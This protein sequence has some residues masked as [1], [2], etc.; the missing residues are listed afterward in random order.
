MVES[1][2]VESSIGAEDVAD[3]SPPAD[4]EESVEAGVDSVDEQE[5]APDLSGL[6][7]AAETLGWSDAGEDL[8]ESVAAVEED[9]GTASAGYVLES[10]GSAAIEA[11]GADE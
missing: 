1:A 10:A 2:A 3:L 11:W 4:E 8:Q 6:Y 7:L 5:I 9:I